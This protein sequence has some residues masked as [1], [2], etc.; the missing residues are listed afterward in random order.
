[1]PTL[2]FNSETMPTPQE[3]ARM[4]REANEQYDII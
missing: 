2:E 4:L 1:M 3:F